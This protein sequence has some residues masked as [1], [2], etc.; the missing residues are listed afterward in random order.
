ML[1][2]RSGGGSL[3]AGSRGHGIDAYNG[4]AVRAPPC[5]LPKFV[6]ELVAEPPSDS[7]NR[8]IVGYA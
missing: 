3:P 8:D 4:G 6:S 5:S 7:I 1:A 2:G